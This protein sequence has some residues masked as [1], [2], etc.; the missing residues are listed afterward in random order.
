MLQYYGFFDSV[1]RSVTKILQ[2]FKFVLQL[3]KLKFLCVYLINLF[4]S[5]FCF[6][7]LITVGYN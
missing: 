6:E 7:N 5:L 4:K 2:F 3:Y 1:T